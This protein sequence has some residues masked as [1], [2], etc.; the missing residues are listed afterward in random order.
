MKSVYWFLIT[1]F[2]AITSAEKAIAYEP[3][4]AYNPPKGICLFPKSSDCTHPFLMVSL[5]ILS[6]GVATWSVRNIP[7]TLRS[8]SAYTTGEERLLDKNIFTFRAHM[9]L[10]TRMTFMERVAIFTEFSYGNNGGGDRSSIAEQDFSPR[11]EYVGYVLKGWN[12]SSSIGWK[13]PIDLTPQIGYR[14]SWMHLQS[15]SDAY[16]TFRPQHEIAIPDQVIFGIAYHLPV[17]PV[18]ETGLFT[19]V[20]PESSPRI[21]SAHIAIGMGMPFV[22]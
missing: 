13:F 5:P 7:K 16:S 1:F 18:F 2:F 21:I 11:D 6:V 22:F 14:V 19:S 12:M 10:G 17:I 4:Y 3:S 9:G 8:A 15:G 20:S